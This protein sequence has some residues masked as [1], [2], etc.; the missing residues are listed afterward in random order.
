MKYDQTIHEKQWESFRKDCPCRK[1]EFC[2]NGLKC[3]K[4]NC[5]LIRKEH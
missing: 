2:T 1:D 3:V 4:E 5:F